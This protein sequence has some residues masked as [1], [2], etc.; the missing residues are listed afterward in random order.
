MSRSEITLPAPVLAAVQRGRHDDA[1][2]MLSL[3]HG[4]SQTEAEEQLALYL[5]QH[6]P[7]R[8]RGGGIGAMSKKG[9]LIAIGLILL[10]GLAYLT[11]GG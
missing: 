2:R 10:L 11:L 3:N 8:M 7:S 9:A 1:I 5:E 4:I 6:P